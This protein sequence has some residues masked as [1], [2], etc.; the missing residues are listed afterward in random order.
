MA[1]ERESRLAG[2]VSPGGRRAEAPGTSWGKAGSSCVLPWVPP[3]EAA[4]PCSSSRPGGGGGGADLTRQA[5]APLSTTQGRVT[6]DVACAQSPQ[7]GLR[8]VFGP[9]VQTSSLVVSVWESAG[10][11]VPEYLGEGRD[12]SC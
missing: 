1:S 2:A 9:G 5:V 3:T 7:T 12:T 8:K 10:L 4:R 6:L 11:G